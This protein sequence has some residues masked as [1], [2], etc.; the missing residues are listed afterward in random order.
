V[1]FRVSTSG[2][3]ETVH[4]LAQTEPEWPLAGLLQE[5]GGAFLGLASHG[6]VSLF[7]AVYR[8][9]TASQ[10]TVVHEFGAA[11][12]SFPETPLIQATDGFLYGTTFWGGGFS[13]GTVFRE[14]LDG[15]FETVH[16][17]ALVDGAYPLSGLRQ[18]A[19][20]S[21]YG[22][23]DWAGAT[24]WGG[25]FAIDPPASFTQVHD[26]AAEMLE[27]PGD[28]I[29]VSDGTLWGAGFDGVI[30]I[31]GTGTPSLVV[32]RPPDDT[33]NVGLTQSSDG[34]I[35]GTGFNPSTFH[36]YVFRVSLQG[37]YEEAHSLSPGEGLNPRAG[38]LLGSDGALY[39]TTTA[40]GVS[41]TGTVIRFDPKSATVATLYSFGPAGSGDGFYSQARLV[42][43]PDGSFYG[44]TYEG[45]LGPYGTVFRITPS[46]RSRW[47]M[48][49]TGRP[50]AH[51]PPP[52]C[53]SDR[54]PRS[55]ALPEAA[56]TTMAESSTAS[57]LP[58]CPRFPRYRQRPAR[59]QGARS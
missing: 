18:A 38:L 7:G 5:S 27:P 8:F 2:A 30:R 29:Q 33:L 39:G 49:S 16:H 55:T 22:T 54:T 20:G 23:T 52:A 11:E 47:S 26:F 19:D 28:L 40:G 9:D 43:A 58:L 34:W 24:T 3:Y 15:A 56:A 57:I 36:S 50:T 14:G 31:D 25:L 12:G 13:F 37:A 35:Y 53:W 41:G 45:G 4:E 46:G 6:P 21:L 42:E 44:T 17:F 51:S 32:A 1:I 59:P 10:L 48:Y